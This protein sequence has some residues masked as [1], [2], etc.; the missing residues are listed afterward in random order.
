MVDAFIAALGIIIDAKMIL[1]LLLGTFTGYVVGFL[2]GL[3]GS[4]GMALLLPATYG[5]DPFFAFALLGGVMGSSAIGGSV[6]AI[7]INTPGQP[8]NAAT[9]FDGYP[10]AKQGRAREALG[11]AAMASLVGAVLGLILLVAFIPFA[12]P[13]V[14]A[15][16]PAEWFLLSVLG[17]TLIASVSEESMLNGLIAG[18]LG[19]MLSFHG[20]NSVTG[21]IRYGFGITYLWDG[22]KFLPALMGVFAIAEMISL[23]TESSS[24]SERGDLSKGSVWTG[25]RAVF[26]NWK[27][28]VQSSVIGVFIGAIPGVG[29][30]VANFLAYSKARQSSKDPQSFGKGNVQG[31][32]ASE[33]SNDAKDGGALMPLLALGI[34][35][36][37][38]TAVLLGALTLHGIIPG[39]AMLTEHL[40]LTFVLIL[41]RVMGGI[42]AA[43]MGLF[44]S[45]KMAKLTLLPT[46]ILAPVV[47]LFIM[48][49]AYG[50]S[51]IV[52]DMFLTI[53]FG[54][55]GYAMK[56][57][58]FPRIPL[59]LGLILGPIAESSFHTAMQFSGYSVSIF[60][61]RP[62]CVILLV[63]IVLS[64][65]MPQWQA[66]KK[67]KAGSA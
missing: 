42:I 23:A 33:A 57:L 53:G 16:G 9:S 1:Y 15:L 31:V 59:I 61:T 38:S 56:K 63:L 11:A 36:S 20:S 52:Y 44:I 51:L 5:I 46:Y 35:G 55:L 28:A 32:I 34:P 29:G 8:M 7:L 22:I 50:A 14:L 25:I 41:A 45:T 12:A 48:I 39:Q 66:Y 65:V 3:T 37:T 4:V 64:V 62:I 17:L 10:M 58:D 54:L 26:T 2:P 21:G 27:I 19:L 43:S 30:T 18:V 60:I 47:V 6:P 67:R 49:G 24:V 13:I 40:D